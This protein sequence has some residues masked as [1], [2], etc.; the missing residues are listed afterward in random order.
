[1][2]TFSKID[3]YVAG[4]KKVV[5]G[6]LTLGTYATGG[7]S[8]APSVFG[9]RG[10]I[11]VKGL[12]VIRKSDSTDAVAGAWKRGASNVASGNVVVYRQKDPGSAGGADVALP[13]VAN[14]TSLT[15]YSAVVEVVGY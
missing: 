12:G 4:N 1:M 2:A 11:N 9:L 13:E 7:E 8:V 6:T 3:S 5:T 15:S 14:S 10:V